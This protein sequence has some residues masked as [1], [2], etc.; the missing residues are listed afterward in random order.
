MGN[1]YFNDGIPEAIIR[2]PLL[3][4][5]TK[6]GIQILTGE[7]ILYDDAGE[8]IDSYLVEI[9]PSPMF[10][11]RFPYLFEIGDKIPRN[12]DWHIYEDT[13]NCC[14]KVLPEEILI[15]KKG[16][17]LCEFIQEQVV[18]YL[19]HQTFRRLNGYF[20]NERS[21]GALGIVEYLAELL[22]TSRVQEQVNLLK[23]IEKRNEPNRVSQCFCG[24]K[25]KYR[26][27]HREAFRVLSALSSQELNVLVK[28]IFPVS[29]HQEYY[30]STQST[31]N[32]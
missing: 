5:V 24:S 15:C 12:A 16:V 30:I 31:M 7:I 21:H 25:Q 17:T 19:F 13:G 26:N 3:K 10:P 22:N 27:C 18:P 9:H 6:N 11:H 28:L 23:F 14:I 8:Q 1:K 2:Y 32:N 29:V 4:A 20:I